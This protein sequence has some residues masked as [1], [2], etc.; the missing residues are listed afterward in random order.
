MVSFVIRKWIWSY[1]NSPKVKASF[2][3]QYIQNKKYVEIE[4]E[5]TTVCFVKRTA[6]LPYPWV[7]WSTERTK[8]LSWSI[9]RAHET[10]ELIDRPS[11]RNAW[12]DRS[13]ERTKHL[14]WSIDR[15]HETPEL[16]DGRSARNA[17]VFNDRPSARRMQLVLVFDLCW[18]KI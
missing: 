2:T 3:Q 14:S 11:A 13:T 10:P 7:D 8:R 1:H 9:Y 18:N 17:W 15:A 6:L 5:N 12:V 16:I 4:K